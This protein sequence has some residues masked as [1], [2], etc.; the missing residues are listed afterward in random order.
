MH[1]TCPTHRIHLDLIILIIFSE[2]YK[3]WSSLCSLLQPPAVYALLGPNIHLS[4]LF[5]NNLNLC[6]FSVR[7]GLTP[8]QKRV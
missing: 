7:P 4:I 8:V 2:V 1:A 5:F 3:L 6:S